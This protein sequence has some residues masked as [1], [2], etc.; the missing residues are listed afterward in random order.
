MLQSGI[1]PYLNALMQHLSDLMVEAAAW[2][3]PAQAHL[4]AFWSHLD[5]LTMLL[6]QPQLPLRETRFYISELWQ[7]LNALEKMGLSGDAF[8]HLGELDKT[9]VYISHLIDEQLCSS[10][11]LPVIAVNTMDT[12]DWTPVK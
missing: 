10:F 6:P 9:L 7:E 11:E 5:S 3:E 2:P 4:Y 1:Q 12:V 8:W